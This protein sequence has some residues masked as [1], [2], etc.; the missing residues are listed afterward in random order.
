MIGILIVAHGALGESLIH[1]ASHVMGARQPHLMNL[2]ITA[3]DDP[4]AI[5]PHARMLVKTLDQGEGVLVFS[6][7]Y[8][9]TPCNIASKLRVP[10]H[11]EVVSGVSL[12]ML[13]RALCYRAKPLAEVVEKAISGGHE[14]VIHVPGDSCSAD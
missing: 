8:G 13:V 11:V 6:D 4:E 10:G 12:P 7:M 9:A 2:G 1:C 5:L 3:H 14:G